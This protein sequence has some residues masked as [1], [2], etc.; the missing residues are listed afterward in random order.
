M[1]GAEEVTWESQTVYC[2][3]CS[4]IVAI[5]TE[6]ELEKYQSHRTMEGILE[7]SHGARWTRG[8]W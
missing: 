6:R 8:P 5:L 4:K 2:A 7:C 1:S 3:K